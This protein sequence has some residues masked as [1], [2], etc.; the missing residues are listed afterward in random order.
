[1]QLGVDGGFWNKEEC[2]FIGSRQASSG[3]KDGLPMSRISVA[4][5]HFV[6][7]SSSANLLE[8]TD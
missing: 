1:L 7:G 4:I 5:D 8:A 6:P 3:A 2:D